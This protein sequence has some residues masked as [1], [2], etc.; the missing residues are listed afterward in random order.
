MPVDLLDRLLLVRTL[1]YSVYEIKEVVRIRAQTENI[2]LT[3]EAID[4]LGEIGETSSLRH[5]VQLLAP[6]GYL[7]RTELEDESEELLVEREHIEEVDCLFNDAK[8][9]A[10]RLAHD[11]DEFIS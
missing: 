2:K 1:P 10:K 11:A 8:T 5:V 3:E 4:L 9:S 6:A 7:A